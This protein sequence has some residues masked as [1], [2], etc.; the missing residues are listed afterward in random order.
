MALVKG[1]SRVDED[2][3]IAIPKNIRK[4]AG[5]SKGQLVEIRVQGTRLAH[6]NIK[7]YKRG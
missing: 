3:R 7:A 5:L 6:I 4:E 1:L 2:G